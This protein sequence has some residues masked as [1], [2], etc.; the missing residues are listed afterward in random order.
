LRDITSEMSA[1]LSAANVAGVCYLAELYFDSGT[2]YIWSGVGTLEWG[3]KSFIGG[4]N[5]VGISEIRENQGLEATGLVCALSGVNPSLLSL[6]L[7]E[8]QRGRPFKLYL[9]IYTA[10]S[11]VLTEDG[12]FVLTEDGGRVVLESELVD[13]PYRVFNG[14]MDTMDIVTDGSSATINLNVESIMLTG[15]KPKQ[16][17][18][19]NE[20]QRKY[21]VN[22]KGLEFIPSLQDKEIVW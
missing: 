10:R 7:T 17:R 5:L 8:R 14:L 15:R 12:G 13:E 16:R 21:Y 19:T 11:Y 18:Y 22:D 6:A 4:G 3:E 9:G 1:A 2:V 20:E